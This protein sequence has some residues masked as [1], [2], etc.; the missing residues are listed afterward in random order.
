MIV[1][2][3]QIII[4]VVIIISALIISWFSLYMSDLAFDAGEM[5]II[6]ASLALP[7]VSNV[8]SEMYF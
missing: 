6:I 7:S 4:M 3:I 1:I 2:I 8:S 5:T